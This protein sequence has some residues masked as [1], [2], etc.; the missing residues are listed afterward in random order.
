MS[1]AKNKENAA[2]DELFDKENTNEHDDE[3]SITLT[4]QDLQ[5]YDIKTIKIENSFFKK[6]LS[7]PGEIS[8][9]E[10]KVSHVVASVPG[11]VNEIYKNLGEPVKRGEHMVSIQSREM[12]EAKAAYMAA[13]KD[14]ELKA[15]L[16]TREE[17]MWRLRAKA[18][19][20]YLKVKNTLETAKIQLEQ[21]SQKL[22]ALGV[23]DA[24]IKNLPNEKG[25][26]NLYYIDAPLDGVIIE[27]HLTRGEVIDKDKQ[28]YVI[29]D[30]S[31]VWVNL[32][33]GAKDLHKIR[34]GQKVIIT[35]NND[36]A[37]AH[38]EVMYVSPMIN[39]ESRTG[40]AIV[41]LDNSND[42]W[43]PGDFV[44]AEI[45][46]PNSES[47]LTVPTAAIQN[48]NGEKFAFIRTQKGFLAKKVATQDLKSNDVVQI[49]S[50]LNIGDEIAVTNTYLLKA[51][52]GKSEAEHSH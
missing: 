12:A 50:G 18:E 49:N 24:E 33:V 19:I 22:L 26:L 7:I 45:Y 25:P 11:V 10:N 41:E 42:K 14:I 37:A 16:F 44:K 6:K 13:Y 47:N 9:N 46:I 36:T 4:P 27:R 31:S 2:K 20:E 38:S 43:H 15:D 51:E 30:L 28:I 40:R 17:K 23:S 29:G 48:I 32:A 1:W 3:L 8:L 52:L 21:T 35:S 39:E 5:K 34:K